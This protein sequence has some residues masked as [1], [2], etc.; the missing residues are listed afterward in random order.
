MIIHRG[1]LTLEKLRDLA[2]NHLKL[3]D[4]SS[5]Y[6]PAKNPKALSIIEQ[7]DGN[8]IGETFKNGKLV[9]VRAGDP[10]SVLLLLI[11]HS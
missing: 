11:T 2:A 1:T 7:P 3:K 10:N 9:Q 8:W 6:N 5:I 4:D